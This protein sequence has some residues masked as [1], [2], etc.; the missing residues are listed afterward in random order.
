MAVT[1]NFESPVRLDIKIDINTTMEFI[2]SCREKH[3]AKSAN[4]KEELQKSFDLL[5]C[6]LALHPLA[7]YFVQQIRPTDREGEPTERATFGRA[8]NRRVIGFVQDKS[9]FEH[10]FKTI[11]REHGTASRAL[12]ALVWLLT[13]GGRLRGTQILEVVRRLYDEALKDK[14]DFDP[15]DNRRILSACQSLAEEMKADVPAEYYDEA[16]NMP[17]EGK[18]SYSRNRPPG[19]LTAWRDASATWYTKLANDEKE[20]LKKQYG[21]TSRKIDVRKDPFLFLEQTS[22]DEILI[23]ENKI[24]LWY[25]QLFCKIYGFGDIAPT[26]EDYEEM[27]KYN[28]HLGYYWILDP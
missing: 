20:R 8:V 22:R 17:D 13:R 5:V 23:P 10:T 28:Q 11:Y 24:T 12:L 9:Y 6:G 7:Q 15:E 18:H 1:A 3:A 19:L 26:L 14:E 4:M 25:G 27:R 16:L 21:V 2:R